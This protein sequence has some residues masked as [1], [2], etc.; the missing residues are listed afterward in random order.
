V[1]AVLTTE[2]TIVEVRRLAVAATRGPVAEGEFRDMA[3][4]LLVRE[5]IDD[6]SELVRLVQELSDA[7]LWM[8]GF[9]DLGPESE[10][11]LHWVHVR[12][13]ALAAALARSPRPVEA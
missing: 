10:S 6:R 2:D 12:D 5:L 7:V 4:P 8:S 11:H 3:T 13:G 9:R 1:A